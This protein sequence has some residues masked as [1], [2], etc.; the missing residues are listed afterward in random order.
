MVMN[1]IKKIIFPVLVILL[2]ASCR[3]KEVVKYEYLKDSTEIVLL[4]SKLFE[5]ESEISSLTS[6]IRSSEQKFKNIVEQLQITETEK[7]LLKETFETT[8]KEYDTE[9]RLIKETYSKRITDF[10]K[11]INSFKEENRVLKED[12][13]NTQEMNT[14]LQREYNR[15]AD[16]VSESNKK[17]AFLE[18]E[19][20]ARSTKREVKSSVI[21]WLCM[22]IGF[23][24]G[25]TAYHYLGELVSI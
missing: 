19:L 12:L 23:S 13:Y 22:L 20:E 8:V 11:E 18:Q 4:K 17:V 3:T 5:Q 1:M 6:E 7:Q 21:W 24:V 15:V 2:L 10:I 25:V 9:G 14:V 16:S